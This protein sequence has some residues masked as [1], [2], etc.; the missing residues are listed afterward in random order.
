MLNYAVKSSKDEQLFALE[1]REHHR[2]GEYGV[3]NQTP[4]FSH[5]TRLRAAG[6]FV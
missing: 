1:V 3:D 4:W 2:L 5:Y 6:Y